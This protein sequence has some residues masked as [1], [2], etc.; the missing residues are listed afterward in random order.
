M[1]QSSQ[2]DIFNLNRVQNLDKILLKN[3]IDESPKAVEM[4][5]R[6]FQKNHSNSEEDISKDRIQR[7]QTVQLLEQIFQDRNELKRSNWYGLVKAGKF[8]PDLKIG[9]IKWVKMELMSECCLSDSGI[10]DL[11]SEEMNETWLYISSLVYSPFFLISAEDSE[12]SVLYWTLIPLRQI[13]RIL[14]K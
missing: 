7:A 3:S 14:E 12:D 2:V 6:H 13:G 4:N 11:I 9:D 8:L 5:R 10:M 1:Q